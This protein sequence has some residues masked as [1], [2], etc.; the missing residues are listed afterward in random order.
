MIGAIIQIATR[1]SK[2]LD[3]NQRQLASEKRNAPSSGSSKITSLTKNAE[4][5]HQ[6]KIDLEQ[7]MD[8]L[9]KG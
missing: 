2:D 8:E 5:L 6:N 4:K 3:N 9:F 7:T 1:V